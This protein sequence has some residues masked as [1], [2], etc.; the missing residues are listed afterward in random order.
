ML[1]RIVCP[2][3]GHSFETDKPNIK[4]CCFECREAGRKLRRLKWNNKHP[5]YNKAYMKQYRQ[6]GRV[7]NND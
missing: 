1:K 2:I 7:T 6:K 4:Y 3:C 5:D